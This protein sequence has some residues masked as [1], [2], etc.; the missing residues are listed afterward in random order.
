[1]NENNVGLFWSNAAETWI[2]TYTVKPNKDNLKKGSL[3]YSESGVLEFVLMMGK[4][5]KE[6]M[7][8]WADVSGYPAIPPYFS[9]GYHQSRWSY[10]TAKEVS[11]VNFQFE[12][13][14]L[15]L[16]AI[17]LDIDVS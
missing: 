13:F 16:D 17:W 12:Y 5:P 3:W 11:E 10:L 4:N 6:I 1:M 2:D 14:E 8:K 15:P 9:L 7:S